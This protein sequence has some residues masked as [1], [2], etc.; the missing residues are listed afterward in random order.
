MALGKT[1]QWV[2][3][4]MQG[5]LREKMR[6][7]AEL[8][9]LKGALPLLMKQ[10]NGGRWTAQERRE[11]QGLLRSA[12]SVSPY[13]FV[14]V[15]IGV[16]P[17]PKRPPFLA[18]MIVM[19]IVMP[20]H[21]FFAISMMMTTT[22]MAEDFYA[23]LQRPYATDLLADQRF[24]DPVE[25]RRKPGHDPLRRRSRQLNRRAAELHAHDRSGHDSADDHERRSRRWF[26]DHER[27][28]GSD[29]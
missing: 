15:L 8:S 17:G 19:I 16:D 22:V 24:N 7:R 14:W 4:M 3:A 12:S 29:I 27:L 25:P 6:I 5:T 1:P 11:L 18:R 26:L 23:L 21:S 2:G 10:R 9:K 13:L 20:L 28:A